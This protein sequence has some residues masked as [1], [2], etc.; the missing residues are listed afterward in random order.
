MNKPKVIIIAV[1][2]LLL[3]IATYLFISAG[4]K[5]VKAEEIDVVTEVPQEYTYKDMME[6]EKNDQFDLSDT[7]R[8]TSA[9]VAPVPEA[10]EPAHKSNKEPAEPVTPA[11]TSPE[12]VAA[13]QDIRR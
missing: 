13:L 4:P 7:I 9:S 12:A 3:I 2:G 10:V 6:A 5:K 1:I 8:K 11:E